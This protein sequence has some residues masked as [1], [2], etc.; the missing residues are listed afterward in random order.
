MRYVA[1]VLSVFCMLN[2]AAQQVPKDNNSSKKIPDRKNIGAGKPQL[3]SKPASK[4]LQPSLA[5]KPVN[6][7]SAFLKSA[8]DTVRFAFTGG[9]M[10]AVVIAKSRRNEFVTVM[11]LRVINYE[12]AFMRLT[13]STLNNELQFRGMVHHP[14]YS[15]ALVLKFNGGAG[16]FETTDQSDV[17]NE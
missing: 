14:S 9:D 6:L 13:K 1:L 17:I 7:G 16:Y 2:C 3:F 12:N 15:D 5:P 11:N 10:I 8:G 4:S